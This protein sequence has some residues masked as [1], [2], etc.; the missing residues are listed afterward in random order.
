MTALSRL[1]GRLAKL[2]PAETHD[3][4]VERDLQVPMPDGVVLL[5]DRYVP[6]KADKLPT[7]LVRTCYGRRGFFGLNYGYLF[8]ER[9]YQVVM[10][11]TRGTFGSGGQ[12]DPFGCEHDDGLATVAWLKQQPWFNGVFATTGASYLGYVQW[13]I[14]REAGPEL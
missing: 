5:A 13:A 2:P 4:I 9:G 3:V 10:Q 7:I 14:A 11:S 6:R 1:I 8:A 12:F